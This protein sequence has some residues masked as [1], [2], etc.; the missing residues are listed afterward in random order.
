MVVL[1]KNYQDGGCGTENGGGTP[2]GGGGTGPGA[3]VMLFTPADI[4]GTGGPVERANKSWIAE[5]LPPK[6]ESGG[7]KVL[8]PK[9]LL[10]EEWTNFNL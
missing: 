3:E 1:M 9:D 7:P 8:V 4:S 5:P 6:R 10:A 2:D